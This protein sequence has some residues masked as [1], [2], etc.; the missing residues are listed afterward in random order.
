MA[1]AK[2]PFALS[3]S[4]GVLRLIVPTLCGNDE[5]DEILTTPP[6]RSTPP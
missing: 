3:L 1:Y 5:N 4:K 2:K 6:L